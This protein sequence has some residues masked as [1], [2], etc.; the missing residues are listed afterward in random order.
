MN[1][2]VLIIV[3]H[4]K[5]RVKAWQ[6]RSNSNTPVL[7]DPGFLVSCAYWVAFQMRIHTDTSNTPGVLIVGKDGLLKWAHLGKGKANW[8][9][10][11]AVAKVLSKI[12]ELKAGQ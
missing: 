7:A 12:E 2:Q 3:P 9:D 11:P 10:R 6:K 4:E 1:A 8:R 5:M